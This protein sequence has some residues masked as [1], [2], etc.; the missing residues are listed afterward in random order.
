VGILDDR[1]IDIEEAQ[2]FLYSAP[3][4]DLLPNLPCRLN[5]KDVAFILSVSVPTQNT[6]AVRV[7]IRRSSARLRLATEFLEETRAGVIGFAFM[8]KPICG[9]FSAHRQTLPV[10]R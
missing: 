9:D 1:E 3:D 10:N 5:A 4:I 7:R 8:H 2:K 6:G